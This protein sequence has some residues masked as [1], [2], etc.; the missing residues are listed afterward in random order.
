M[1]QSGK[2]KKQAKDYDAEAL[3]E[4]NAIKFNAQDLVGN[5]TATLSK[6]VQ[7]AQNDDIK[8]KFITKFHQALTKFTAA[9]VQQV[10]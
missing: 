8:I 2:I 5:V 10:I 7:R 9:N 1:D 6:N 3:T 4:L